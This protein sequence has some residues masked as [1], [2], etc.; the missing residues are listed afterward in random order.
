MNEADW[1]ICDSAAAMLDALWSPREPAFERFVSSTSAKEHSRL[2]AELS[3]ALHRYY[4]ASCRAIWSL[5]PQQES[6]RGIELAEQLLSGVVSEAD[7][8]AY[9]PYVEGAAFCIDYN[10]KPDAIDEWVAEVRAIPEAEW[11][12][13][14]HPPESVREV[15]P[16][17][18]LVRAAYFADYAMMYPWLRPEGP[19]PES[20]R[21]FL[22]AP[23]LR[24]YVTYP[25]LC[26]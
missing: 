25:R 3:R 17:E 24:E 23:L 2:E 4:L 9:N 10:T 18:L 8:Q 19:P 13:T 22:S 16:R 5:L 6:R 21:L 26:L 20:Y 7:V 14:L 11:Q 15:E 12:F 1:Q